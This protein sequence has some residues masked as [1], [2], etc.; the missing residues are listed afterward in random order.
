MSDVKTVWALIRLEVYGDA[1]LNDIMAESDYKVEHPTI[2]ET[3]FVE[4]I[5]QE[6]QPSFRRISYE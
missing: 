1:D 2:V 4:L 6:T 5:E 3:E